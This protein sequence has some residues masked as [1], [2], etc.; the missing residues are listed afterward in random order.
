M[1]KDYIDI[2]SSEFEDDDR[3]SSSSEETFV[4][5]KKQAPKEF[6]KFEGTGPQKRFA[7]DVKKRFENQAQEGEIKGWVEKIFDTTWLIE[8]RFN[9]INE[10]YNEVFEI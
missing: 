5:R 2:K 4:P 3:Q 9:N 7:K 6:E 10:V 1:I 8:N